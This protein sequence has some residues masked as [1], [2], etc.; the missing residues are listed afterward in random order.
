MASL[1][2]WSHANTWE[3][4]HFFPI[5]AGQHLLG[6]KLTQPVVLCLFLLA[7]YRKETPNSLVITLSSW[8]GFLQ[9]QER[10]R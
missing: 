7:A 1:D 3:M 9:Q 4:H 8:Q 10:K 2:G 5:E 6:E